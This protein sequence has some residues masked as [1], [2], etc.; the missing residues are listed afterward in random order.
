MRELTLESEVTLVVPDDDDRTKQALIGLTTCPVLVADPESG[1]EL[2]ELL[3]QH[4]VE[5][6][7]SSDVSVEVYGDDELIVADPDHPALLTEDCQW[8]A[9]VVALAAELKS[10]SFVRHTEQSIRQVLDRLRS[11]RIVRA[12]D[13]RILVGDEEMAPPSQTTSLPIEDEGAPTVVVWA[14][15]GTVFDQ[16]ERSADSVAYLVNQTHLAPVLQLAFTRL[17]QVCPSPSVLVGDDMLA[18]ALQVSEEQVRETR[19]DLRGP[20]VGL[21]DRVRAPVAD[22]GDDDVLAT[23][24]SKAHDASSEA[25]VVVVLESMQGS[26]PFPASELVIHCRENGNLAE[27]RDAGRTRLHRLQRGPGEARPAHSCSCPSGAAR[28]GDGQVHRDPPGRHPLSSSRGLSPSGVGT[29]RPHALRRG[30]CAR[31]TRARPGMVGPLRR[32]SR[33]PARRE[34]RDVARRPW[35]EP[36]SRPR[37]AMPEVTSLRTAN[38]GRLDEVVRDAELRLRACVEST[39]VPL[40]RDGAHL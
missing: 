8:I 15:D 19:A 18:H 6:M 11:I 37:T 21:L 17:G 5:V 23:F 36:G 26:L 31:G 29:G 38:F 12:Q 28:A 39:E 3:R 34:G 7:P 16:L 10:G 1:R 13:V 24:D 30:P 40:H 14:N 27:L 2:T 9:V 25:E 4:G 22:D 33:E 32:A 35:G 20:I